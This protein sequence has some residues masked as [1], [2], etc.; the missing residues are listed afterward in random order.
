MT[1][2]GVNNEDS[3]WPKQGIWLV[4]F[5]LLS[6]IYESRLLLNI[7]SKISTKH[8]KQV[9][10]EHWVNLPSKCSIFTWALLNLEIEMIQRA[11]EN[12]FSIYE[13]SIC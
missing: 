5:K 4:G 3:F 11:E 10:V 1:A 12:H 8:F 2:Q 9:Y 6:T 7:D 13:R